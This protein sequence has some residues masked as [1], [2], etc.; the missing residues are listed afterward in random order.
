MFA[1]NSNSVCV[2]AKLCLH[3]IQTLF[4]LTK[5]FERTK[6]CFVCVNA[7]YVW[8]SRCIVR[9]KKVMFDVTLHLFVSTRNSVWCSRC[10]VRR[11][12][13]MFD[14]IFAMFVSTRNS[15]WCDA[16]YDW[17][18]ATDVWLDAAIVCVNAAHVSLNAKQVKCLTLFI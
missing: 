17:L 2:K 16:A 11:K 18:N 5:T 1:S 14:V 7:P 6:K 10:T 12:K 9:R 15:V 8:C 4:V 13:A 3:Q